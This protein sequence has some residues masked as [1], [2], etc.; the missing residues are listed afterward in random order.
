MVLQRAP[1]QRPISPS[2]DSPARQLT[3]FSPLTVKKPLAAVLA[4]PKKVI[5][6]V[7]LELV[8][9]PFSVKMAFAAVAFPINSIVP[10][11]RSGPLA[12][13][14]TKTALLALEKSLKATSPPF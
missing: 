12:E 6:A 8:G 7:A 9:E 2:S 4:N 1:A 11:P 13:L 14:R 3:V 5:L 10:A